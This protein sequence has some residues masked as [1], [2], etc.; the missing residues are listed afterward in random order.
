MRKFFLICCIGIIFCLSA[1]VSKNDYE[2]LSQEVISLQ[3]DYNQLKE[4]YSSLSSSL[5]ETQIELSALKLDVE[6]SSVEQQAKNSNY[7][8]IYEL[9]SAATS[10][11][12]IVYTTT[13]SENGMA[14]CGWL[15]EGDITEIKSL[16]GIEYI[17]VENDGGK[18]AVIEISSYTLFPED[19][20][21]GDHILI[22]IE[23]VGF[24]EALNLPAGYF[25]GFYI[26]NR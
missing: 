13:G 2:L 20:K 25:T 9:Y 11:P 17:V 3:N 7:D 26:L 18:F 15:L 22:H 1:C 19:W 6:N 23:Y 5:S 8:E 10:I 16:S 24:A 4:E 14:G 21:V 12:D